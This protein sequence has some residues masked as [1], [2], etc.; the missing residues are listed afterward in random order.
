MVINTAFSC[1][2]TVRYSGQ[3]QGCDSLK[4]LH[5]ERSK[6]L[7]SISMKGCRALERVS[8]DSSGLETL[9]CNN[10][11]ALESLEV[12]CAEDF[13]RLDLTNC[14]SLMRLDISSARQAPSE[15]WRRCNLTLSGT[16]KQ[17]KTTLISL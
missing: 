11:S 9:E 5:I 12:T 14:C 6:S 15:I 4:E 17:L 2:L 16:S 10:C 7:Q 3:T 13:R 8:V 1:Y